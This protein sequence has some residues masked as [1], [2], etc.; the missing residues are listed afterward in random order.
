MNLVLPRMDKKLE[1]L[2]NQLDASSDSLSNLQSRGVLEGFNAQLLVLSYVSLVAP[3]PLQI[4]ILN[5]P[6]ARAELQIDEIQGQLRRQ[7]LDCQF[8]TL[9]RQILNCS[10]EFSKCASR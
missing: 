5:E 6:L 8:G 7:C 4:Q 2:Y 10:Y 1:T 3:N 9:Y